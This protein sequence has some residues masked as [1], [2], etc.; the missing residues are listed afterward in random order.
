[1]GFTHLWLI[2][3]VLIWRKERFVPVPNQDWGVDQWQGAFLR[4]IHWFIIIFPFGAIVYPIY[5]QF[6]AQTQPHHIKSCSL[7]FTSSLYPLICHSTTIFLENWS[8]NH[9]PPWLPRAP[10]VHAHLEV[11]IRSK[12]LAKKAAGEAVLRTNTH[13]HQMDCRMTLWLIIISCIYVI[14]ILYIY[15]FYVYDNLTKLS[16][17]LYLMESE[18][19]ELFFAVWGGTSSVWNRTVGNRHHVHRLSHK[20][21]S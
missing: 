16:E 11:W 2:F 5:P 7:Q 10:R 9:Q 8:P 18:V 15:M 1:M 3:G 14:C 12:G 20:T 21:T 19:F 4:Q 6:S 17:P 13:G